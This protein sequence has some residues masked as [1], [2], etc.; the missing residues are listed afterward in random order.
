[1]T[2]LHNALTFNSPLEAGIRAVALLVPAYPQAYDLQRLVAFDH[3]VVHTGD[4][5]GPDSLHPRLPLRSTELLVRRKLIERGLSLMIS[6]GLIERIIDENGIGYRAGDLAATF[7]STFASPY[8][9]TLRER[10]GW[11][12]EHF[13]G[14]CDDALRQTISSTFGQWIEEFQAT[15]RSIMVET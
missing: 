15:Q 9:I 6:R 1:M 7:L 14:F 12:V 4:I 11:V 10:G 13:Q 2:T 8:L 5:G 3:I